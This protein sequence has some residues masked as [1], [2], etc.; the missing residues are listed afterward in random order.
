MIDNCSAHK[1]AEMSNVM[2]IFLPPN[3]TSVIQPLD[4]GIIRAFKVRSLGYSGTS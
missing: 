4:A 3:M 2:L 1:P